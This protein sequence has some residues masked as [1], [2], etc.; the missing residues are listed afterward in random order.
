MNE[1]IFEREL[2]PAICS[3]RSLEPPGRLL[4]QM[5]RGFFVCLPLTSLL[6]AFRVSLRSALPIWT[7]ASLDRSLGR[8]KSTEGEKSCLQNGLIE[9][10]S[11]PISARHGHGRGGSRLPSSMATSKATSKFT[12]CHRSAYL[13]T[14]S[15][16]T[17][18]CRTRCSPKSTNEDAVHQKFIFVANAP[19]SK[20]IKTW[21][22]EIYHSPSVH[23]GLLG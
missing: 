22:R 16:I 9:T 10:A 6:L 19:S 23:L 20:K 1:T 2:G 5:T 4:A 18:Q 12:Y 8:R 3:Q 15:R 11:C 14:P 7:A 21:R 17:K 13:V